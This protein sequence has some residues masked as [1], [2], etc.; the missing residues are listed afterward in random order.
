MEPMIKFLKKIFYRK[1]EREFRGCKRVLDLG[2]GRS[3]ILERL[4][5]DYYSVGVDAFSPYLEESRQKGIH[6]EYILSDIM[7][8]DFPDKS[9]DAV[10]CC[11]VIEHLTPE[12]ARVLMKKVERWATKKILMT[13]PNCE[14]GFSP[15]E[16]GHAHTEGFDRY[17]EATVMSHKSGWTVD[18]FA[19][20][21][22]RARG[23]QGFERLV[24]AKGFEKLLYY[25]SLPLSYF[26]PRQAYQ[27]LAIKDIMGNP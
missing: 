14:S 1:I 16:E 18:S 21:G 23:Y 9:F 27:L 5:G 15:T 3:S 12:D 4:S 13:T 25:I 8:V 7:K 20:L 22:Y 17:G 19:A 10:V 11:Q 2:C 24:G 6:D 26:F